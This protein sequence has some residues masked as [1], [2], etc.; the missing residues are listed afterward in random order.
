MD[1]AAATSAG[2]VA[3]AGDHVRWTPSDAVLLHPER[4]APLLPP[5]P[6]KGPLAAEWAAHGGK[7]GWG[8]ALLA[9]GSAWLVWPPTADDG[10]P[11]WPFGV[12][13]IVAGLGCLAWWQWSRRGVDAQHRLAPGDATWL[14]GRA[15]RVDVPLWTDQALICALLASEAAGHL[16]VARVIE[17]GAEVVRVRALAGG[18]GAWPVDALEDRLRPMGAEDL[19][20]MVRDWL[21]GDSYDPGGRAARL[22]QHGLVSRRLG[23]YLHYDERAHT[24]GGRTVGDTY[25][26]HDQAEAQ[27]DAAPVA[28]AQAL[29][30]RCQRERPELWAA[31]RRAIASGLASRT[32]APDWVQ[33]GPLVSVPEYPHV[34]AP[35]HALDAVPAHG[36]ANDAPPV[37]LRARA[38]DAA[39]DAVPV[40][41]PAPP[42]TAVL[43]GALAVAALAVVLPPSGL[44]DFLHS[45]AVAM[46]L[47]FAAASAAFEAWQVARARRSLDARAAAHPPPPRLAALAG[48]PWQGVALVGTVYGTLAALVGRWGGEGWGGL[49]LLLLAGVQALVW[50]ARH[51]VEPQDVVRAVSA[52][53]A[54]RQQAGRRALGDAAMSAPPATAQ[55]P[56]P[57]GRPPP[58]VLMTDGDALPEADPGLLAL[59]R[60]PAARRRALHRLHWGA[61]AVLVAGAATLLGGMAAMASVGSMPPL[62]EQAVGTLLLV[63]GFLGGVPLMAGVSLKALAFDPEGSLAPVLPRWIATVARVGLLTL[64]L[65]LPPVPGLVLAGWVLLQWLGLHLALVRLGRRHPLLAPARLTLLRVFDAASFEDFAELIAP[66]RGVGLIEY[67]EGPDTIGQRDDVRAAVAEGRLDEVVAKTADEVRQR[68]AAA[69]VTPDGELRFGSLSFPCANDT[70][71]VAVQGLL[72]RS[73]AVVMDLTALSPA[74]AGCAWELDQLLDRVPLSRVTLLVNDDTDLDCLHGILA[75]CAARIAAS[76]PNLADPKAQWRVLRIGGYAKRQGAESHFQWRRRLSRRLDATL[77]SAHLLASAQPLRSQLPAPPSP[78]AWQGAWHRVSPLGVAAVVLLALGLGRLA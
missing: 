70:W 12:G 61:T 26:L 32:L 69:P 41:L 28:Q 29:L 4:F 35:L 75:A 59:L 58:P 56:R 68:L 46:A 40:G 55:A 31:L 57:G 77:L 36:A 25:A 74:N 22:L 71:Q 9:L 3:A 17:D 6:P 62:D 14:L 60:R 34:E 24:Q 44:A 23:G 21:A 42:W 65:H 15:V 38:D 66:W 13:F 39:A 7:V 43:G 49:A 72:D 20:S 78:K 50:L 51:H 11:T 54:A 30:D 16:Q 19:A 8:A 52:H 67:L 37:G 45:P 1:A 2:G 53:L 5:V 33:R 64:A 47:V 63:F 73:D 27:R 10:S 76:S 48:K 18:E